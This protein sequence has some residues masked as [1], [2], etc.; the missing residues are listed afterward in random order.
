[1]KSPGHEMSI[2]YLVN[3]RFKRNLLSLWVKN[4]F[5]EGSKTHRK[6]LPTHYS[7]TFLLWYFGFKM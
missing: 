4:G 2:T 3:Y 7:P 5:G 1:M 6:Q